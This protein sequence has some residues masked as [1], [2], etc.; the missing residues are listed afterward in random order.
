MRRWFLLV[1]GLQLFFLL[2][3]A[4]S[5][6]VRIR[7]SPVILLKTEPV[8]PRSLFMGN[9][10]SLGYEISTLNLSKVNHDPQV[11][12]ASWGDTV[13]V[14]LTP[15]KPWA[16]LDS[17][18]AHPPAPRPGR[19]YLRGKVQWV[20][21][22]ASG[23]TFRPGVP[24][25]GPPE[26]RVSYRLERFYIPESAQEQVQRLTWGGQRR[27]PVITVEV[28]VLGDGEAVIRRVLVDGKP[29]VF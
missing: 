12:N 2:A 11:E 25:P 13:Y 9:Y 14:T 10:M 19:V 27:Q 20:H 5:Y 22:Y 1:V 29:L 8:D 17:V 23:A 4:G 15:A 3:E 26:I 24:P 16:R 21:A 18:S 7:R 28:S 6:E